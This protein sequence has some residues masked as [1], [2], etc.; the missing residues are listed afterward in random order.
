MTSDDFILAIQFDAFLVDCVA[1]EK[2]RLF[3]SVYTATASFL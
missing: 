3:F 2:Q 1:F